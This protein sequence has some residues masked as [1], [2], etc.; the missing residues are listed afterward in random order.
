MSII[1]PTVLPPETLRFV[2]DWLVRDTTPEIEVLLPAPPLTPAEAM[3][4]RPEPA[5]PTI[6]VRRTT[7]APPRQPTGGPGWRLDVAHTAAATN[8][9]IHLEIGR[10]HV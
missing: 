6:T 9:L 3:D 10:A 2:K 1:V 7:F 4:P 5:L 8:P